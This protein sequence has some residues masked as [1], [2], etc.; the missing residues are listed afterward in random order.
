MSTATATPAPPGPLDSE[1]YRLA[2]PSTACAAKLARDFIA[3]LLTLSSHRDLVDDARLCVTEVVANA[4]R[5]TQTSLIGVEA[6]VLRTRVTVAVTDDAHWA[7]PAPTDF[8]FEPER[9]GGQ[10]LLRVERLALAWGATILGGNVP[11]RKAVWFTLG[12]VA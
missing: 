7:L 6:A 5:H 12:T 10:G 11:C 4:H 3:S 9:V 8:R 1:T 2:L